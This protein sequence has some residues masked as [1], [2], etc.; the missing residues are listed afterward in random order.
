[1]RD[2]ASFF[3]WEIEDSFHIS[4]GGKGG[5]DEGST[6]RD[7]LAGASRRVPPLHF[8]GIELRIEK[9]RKVVEGE[10]RWDILREGYDVEVWQEDEIDRFSHT[11]VDRWV[12]QEERAQVEELIRKGNVYG[13]F[14]QI[15][16]IGSA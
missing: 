10:D 2:H 13:W 5:D 3:W 14:A 7:E 8:F 16:L 11:P 6:F 9:P 4:L 15:W 1:M 12:A